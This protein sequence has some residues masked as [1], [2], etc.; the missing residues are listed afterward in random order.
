[1]NHPPCKDCPERG[2]GTKHDTCEKFAEWQKINDRRKAQR[3]QDAVI[4]NVVLHH[5]HVAFRIWQKRGGRG[6]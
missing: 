1:M 5:R 3:E 6:K 4:D 2:C